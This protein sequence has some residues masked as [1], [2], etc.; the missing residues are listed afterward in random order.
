MIDKA[1]IGKPIDPVECLLNGTGSKDNKGSMDNTGNNVDADSMDGTDNTGDTADMDDTDG[2]GG[3][4]GTADEEMA[5][6]QTAEGTDPP[7]QFVRYF[8]F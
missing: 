6:L 5:G 4:D 1:V 7:S 8:P 3:T 2:T